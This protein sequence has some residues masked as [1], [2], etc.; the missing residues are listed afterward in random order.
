MKEDN[1]W[2]KGKTVYRLITKNN[3]QNF[4]EAIQDMSS[5]G[6]I[7]SPIQPSIDSSGPSC[8]VLMEKQIWD[9]I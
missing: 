2:E 9:C 6:Y 4:E 5:N 3:W 7:I 8:W 1:V